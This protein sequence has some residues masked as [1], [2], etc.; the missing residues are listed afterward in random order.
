MA[1]PADY[2]LDGLTAEQSAAVRSEARRLLVVAGAGSGKTEVMSRR[3][4]W[5]VRVDGVSKGAIAAFTFTNAAAEEMKFRVRRQIQRT[6][7]DDEDVTLGDMY[8]GTIHS[9]CLAQ[10]R[11]HA[12]DEYYNYDVIDEAAR[13]ALV[14]RGFNSFLGLRAFQAARGISQ[15]QA[16]KEF[17]QAYDLLNE[18]GLLRVRLPTAAAPRD[19]RGEGDWVRAAQMETVIGVGDAAQAFAVSAARYYAYLRARRFLDFSTAQ[20]EFIRQMEESPEF[21]DAVRATFKRVM[22]DE[23][24]DVNAVQDRLIRLVL[25]DDGWLTAVGDHRQAIYGFRGS[26]VQIMADLAAEL[27]RDP[28]GEVLPLS[29]NFRSTPRIVE[30]ANDWA[31]TITAV[32]AFPAT[33]M[34]GRVRAAFGDGASLTTEDVVRAAAAAIRRAGLPMAESVED[35][36]LHACR[37]LHARFD[38]GRAATAGEVAPL[39]TP[40]LRAYLKRNPSRRVFPQQVFQFLVAEAELWRWDR[41]DAGARAQTA[42]FHVGAFSTLIKGMETPGWTERS[43]FR[44]QIIGLCNWGADNARTDEAP[45]LVEPDAVR[46]STIHG[47]KGLEYAVV[48]LADLRAQ[49]FPSSRARTRPNLPFEGA[50]A[51]TIDAGQLADNRNYD[52]ERRLMYV[53]LTRAER[54]LFVTATGARQPKFRRELVPIIQGA[55]GVV[56]GSPSPAIPV[57]DRTA[58]REAEQGNRLVTSFSDLRYYL[59]CPHDFYLRKVLGFTPTIDQAFGYG[60]AVHNL[61]RAVHGDPGRWAQLAQDP[62]RL[63]AE[64]RTLVDSGLFYLRYTTGDPERQM[65]DKAARILV[66]YVKT[67]APELAR[68]QFE[69]ERAFETLID[70]GDVLVAGAIDLVRLDDPPR[71]SLIDF[72][73]GV[74]D[75]DAT[76]RMDTEE[77]RLQISLYGLAARKELE[78]QPEMGLLR[79]LGETDPAARELEVPLTDEVLGDARDKVLAMAADIRARRFHSGPAKPATDGKH[80]CSAC[81]FVSFCGR[82][83]AAAHRS[84]SGGR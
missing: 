32:P 77:M 3:V 17:L 20:G 15:T 72:K 34:A 33:G 55:G 44:W 47:A 54:F 49:R 78:Y 74:Q 71:V 45:L 37:L 62:Q 30:V 23:F 4:A 5:W 50:L 24:Q 28:R 57:V 59:E 82:P 27:R 8:V 19:F 14:A 43:E 11:E 2:L 60:K 75:G 36:V 25:G 76:A 64:V 1:D 61:M 53:A 35:R 40:T 73:S 79:Y 12:P 31:R 7:S 84:G 81:D 63:E 70:E 65:R 42:M 10:L 83:E 52:A 22:V 67:Y 6:T 80:R 46:I 16:T 69:P 41:S 56:L 9:F 18:Y 39:A 21:H 68:M 58:P 48:F 26:R 13:A 66:D 38:Q 51:Q 29:A